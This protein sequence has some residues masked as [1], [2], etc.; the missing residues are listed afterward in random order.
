MLALLLLLLSFVV[1]VFVVVAVVFVVWV[2]ARV[3]SL[4]AAELIDPPL[5][6]TFHSKTG[7]QQLVERGDLQLHDVH[8]RPRGHPAPGQAAVLGALLAGRGFFPA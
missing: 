3:L 4:F 8:P 5:H 1:V 7:H 6:Q 2:V